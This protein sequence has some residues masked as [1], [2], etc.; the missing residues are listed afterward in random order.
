MPFKRA[1]APATIPEAD[2]LTSAL[3]GIGMN[4]AVRPLR[5]PNIE[6]TLLF[7]SVEAME[8]DDLRVLAILVTWFGVHHPWVNGDRL[9]KL[10]GEHHS[11]R[12][13]ALW[14]A[15][16]QWQSTDRR[17]ARLARSYRGD[18][19]DLVAAGTEFQIR[20]YG[21]DPRFAQAPLR[22]PENMLRDRAQDVLTPAELA[23]RHRAYRFRVMMGPCYRADMWAALDEEPSLS[24]AA[25]A[26]RTYGSFATAWHVRRDYKILR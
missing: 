9:V 22:V 21:E 19:L 4:F 24:A 11:T 8:K 18:R 13:R 6:D 5:D 1:I 20:R 2:T 17:F 14:A 12:V 7:A 10:V 3:A 23:K 16:A 25:L 26:R 15:L